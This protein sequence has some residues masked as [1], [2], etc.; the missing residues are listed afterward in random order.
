LLAYYD[1][2]PAEHL[3]HL[4]TTNPSRI[5]VCD[6]D[7]GQDGP[8]EGIGE[9]GRGIG[10][11]LQAVRDY[12]G[13]VAKANRVLVLVPPVRAEGGQGHARKWRASRKSRREGCRV[14]RAQKIN[15]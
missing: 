3:R 2:F 12:P 9:P 10:D 6:D 15:I 1:F 7:E 4:R 13:E 11:L 5:A 8:H 14:I